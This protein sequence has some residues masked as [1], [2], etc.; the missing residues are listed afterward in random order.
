M[1]SHGAAVQY[2]A[3]SADWAGLGQCPGHAAC[4]RLPQP[5]AGPPPPAP[6]HAHP[7]QPLAPQTG[8]SAQPCIHA[9]EQLVVSSFMVGDKRKRLAPHR[10]DCDVMFSGAGL[11]R[12]ETA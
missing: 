12:C 6:T 4:P 11:F 7:G 8:F 2:G 3:D 9:E 1:C 5:H 10:P